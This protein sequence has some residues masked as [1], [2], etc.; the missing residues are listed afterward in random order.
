MTS[1]PNPPDESRRP[2]GLTV[3]TLEDRAAPALFL[4]G[5]LATLIGFGATIVA[6]LAGSGLAGVILFAAGTAVLT[7]GLVAA[8]GSQAI[9]RRAAGVTTYAG[10][11][12]VLVFAASVSATL[13]LSALIGSFLVRLGLNPDASLFTLVG[14]LIIFGSYLGL[15]RF[16]VVG[17]GALT[18][19]DMGFRASSR[20]LA[21]DAALGV[22]LAVPVLTVTGIL[23]ALLST[24]LPLPDPVLPPA[25]DTAGVLLNL[26]V[27]AVIAPIGEELFFRGFATTAWAR[28]YGARRGLIQGAVF[29]AVAHVLTLG[30]VDPVEGLKLAL[31]ASLVRL[32][33]AVT[34]GSLFLRR[35]SLVAPIFLHAAYNGLPIIALAA[36]LGN[37]PGT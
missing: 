11:S 1:D 30:A 35:R 17:T 5:W 27:A 21:E 18:W 7:I 8:A 24:F 29:F 36:G 20:G 19:R 13:F 33:V 12:P 26:A 25:T 2:L 37:A 34:L 22:A 10:P 16:L 23:A 32:P 3:F 28:V 14:S 31:F 6:A 15:V 4:I 9:E